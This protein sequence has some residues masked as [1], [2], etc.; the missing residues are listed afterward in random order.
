MYL[1]TGSPSRFG[2][3]LLLSTLPSTQP[4]SL[5]AP[6][7]A[8]Q[9]LSNSANLMQPSTST[10]LAYIHEQLEVDESDEKLR[11]EPTLGNGI[12]AV[13][14]IGADLAAAHL[15]ASGGVPSKWVMEDSSDESD[16]EDTGQRVQNGREHSVDDERDSAVLLQN[17]KHQ[18]GIGESGII[19][20]SHEADSDSE[21][22]L[23]DDAASAAEKPVGLPRNASKGRLVLVSTRGSPANSVFTAYLSPD[24]AGNGRA[25]QA[26]AASSHCVAAQL[27]VA[28]PMLLDIQ[29]TFTMLRRVRRERKAAWIR[30][31]TGSTSQPG[32][33][34]SSSRWG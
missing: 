12:A 10:T 5:P 3:G 15:A 20:S 28:D 26:S 7:A 31:C 32:A 25:E 2:N 8:R 11:R 22:E 13:G 18:N 19:K 6:E 24:D 23:D 16:D 33:L 21:V 34:I 9:Q 17:G 1:F 30:M 27:D 4:W 29:C 14:S